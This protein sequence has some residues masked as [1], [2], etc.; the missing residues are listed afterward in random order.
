MR[1]NNIVTEILKGDTSVSM[2]KDFTDTMLSLPDDEESLTFGCIL[3]SI[4]HRIKSDY[5][6]FNC[7]NALHSKFNDHM[8]KYLTEEPNIINHKQNKE[9]MKQQ[10]TFL[11]NYYKK[12]E[13]FL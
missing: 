1:L 6:N 2:Y 9:L 12:N 8:E 11:I 4:V 5:F 7:F 10:E 13:Y 3:I